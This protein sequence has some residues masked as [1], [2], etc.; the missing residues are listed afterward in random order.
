MLVSFTGMAETMFQRWKQSLKNASATEHLVMSLLAYSD[1]EDW[2]DSV[3][4]A[5]E[6][7]LIMERMNAPGLWI[8]LRAFS[9]TSCGIFKFYVSIT[10]TPDRDAITLLFYDNLSQN[11]PYA[12]LTEPNTARMHSHVIVQ[13]QERLDGHMRAMGVCLAELVIGYHN[14]TIH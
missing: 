10:V 9:E 4:K 12:L 13:D 6:S 1:A 3:P 8:C 2:L 5:R 11:A 14:R 7:Q